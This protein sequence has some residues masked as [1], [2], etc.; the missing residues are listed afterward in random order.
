M[1]SQSKVLNSQRSFKLV[2]IPAGSTPV[3]LLCCGVNRLIVRSKSCQCVLDLSVFC[4]PRVLNF[5]FYIKF[6]LVVKGGGLRRPWD[7][8]TQEILSSLRPS[9]M[10]PNKLWTCPDNGTTRAKARSHQWGSCRSVRRGRGGDQC[11]Q[12]RSQGEQWWFGHTRLSEGGQGEE[13]RRRF[14]IVGACPLGS[15]ASISW[16]KI[17]P[18]YRFD[19]TKQ[20]TLRTSI[21][22]SILILQ[23]TSSRFCLHLLI[24]VT[25]IT[26]LYTR[27]SKYR[28]THTSTRVRLAYRRNGES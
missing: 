12:R 3:D 7:P 23:V 13:V 4:L 17:I 22:I 26:H 28:H 20:H 24:F 11:S 25:L 18:Q 2:N 5:K 15:L 9:P 14:S 10:R 16:G 21:S 1:V 6:C 8:S 27:R 19:K